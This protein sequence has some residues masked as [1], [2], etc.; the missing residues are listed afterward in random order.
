MK[1][2][3][4]H[5][6]L[7]RSDHAIVL[8]GQLSKGIH[9][10]QLMNGEQWQRWVPLP[11][12]IILGVGFMVHGWAKWSRGPAAF[13][14]LLKQAHRFADVSRICHDVVTATQKGLH[15][16]GPDALR[17]PRHNDCFRLHLLQSPSVN[18]SRGAEASSVHFRNVT[19]WNFQK[20]SA[21]RK[22]GWSYGYISALD[23]FTR[24]KS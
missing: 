23:G 17:S 6:F 7:S 5:I 18:V 16:T 11:I 12:R 9:M 19:L 13:G 2:L 1:T 20:G 3:T 22:A 21:S 10:L 15:Q 14:E 24:M 4:K 8:R